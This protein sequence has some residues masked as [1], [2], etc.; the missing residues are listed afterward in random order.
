MATVVECLASLAEIAKQKGFKTSLI[1]V[2][3]DT[4]YS[5][6]SLRKKLTDEEMFDFKQQLVKVKVSIYVQ[7]SKILRTLLQRNIRSKWPL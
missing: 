1:P 6:E 4:E 7:F 5:D 2:K 3:E